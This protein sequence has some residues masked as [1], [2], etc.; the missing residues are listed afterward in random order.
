M[1]AE[2]ALGTDGSP[3]PG[4]AYGTD[5]AVPLQFQLGCFPL[6]NLEIWVFKT[7]KLRE[8]CGFFM[9][10]LY[11]IQAFSLFLLKQLIDNTWCL[12]FQ[13]LRVIFF[14]VFAKDSYMKVCIDF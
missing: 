12:R 6:G 9:V 8:G 13:A 10:V 3:A 2:G 5:G 7:S 4:D 1:K 11:I 14:E